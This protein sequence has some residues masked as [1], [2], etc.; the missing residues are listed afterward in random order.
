MHLNREIIYL[1]V[2]QHA[3]WLFADFSLTDASLPRQR[4]RP[5]SS[6]TLPNK[7][8]VLALTHRTVRRH[9]TFSSAP[10]SVSGSR[11]GVSRCH[12]SVLQLPL[13]P[14]RPFIPVILRKMTRQMIL[15]SILR[16]WNLKKNLQSVPGYHR[17]ERHL[18]RRQRGWR[19]EKGR[20]WEIL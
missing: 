10:A 8:N 17:V 5:S 2:T 4:N 9:P 6:T 16:I 1:L 11:T 3:V 14:R 12:A 18:E 15:T 20:D 19:R 13:T 7:S